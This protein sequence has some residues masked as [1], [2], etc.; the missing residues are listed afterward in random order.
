MLTIFALPLPFKD[1]D[2]FIQRNAIGSW[3]RL[4]PQPEILLLGDDDGVAE[5]AEEHGLRHIP[6]VAKNE[7]NRYSCDSIFELGQEHASNDL[8]MY[9]DADII[10][11]GESMH[12]IRM[13]ADEYEKFLVVGYRKGV[14]FSRDIDF[15]LTWEHRLHQ[16]VTHAG[17]DFRPK[18]RG[19]TGGGA[20]SDYFVFPRGL[21]KDMP[22]FTVGKGHWDGW[23]MWYAKQQGATL[24]DASEVIYA[25]HQNHPWRKW[26]TGPAMPA[27]YKLTN[28]NA[29]TLWTKDADIVLTDAWLDKRRP[30]LSIV[31]RCYKRP[32]MLAKNR[33]SAGAQIEGDFEQ[34]FIVDD[35]GKGLHWANR[36][37]HVNRARAMG[38]YVLILDD[39]DMFVDR[40]AIRYLK[41]ITEKHD[42]DV[43]I[44]KMDQILRNLPDMEWGK[45]IVRAHIGSC[46][47]VVKRKLWYD[48]IYVFGDP[49]GGLDDW[50]AGDCWF[51]D[52]LMKTGCSVYWFDKVLT[53]TQRVSK[54]NPE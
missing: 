9:I 17:K 18:Q 51:I 29:D 12:A 22:P 46:C 54:G 2:A 49:P 23:K 33:V 42:P 24:I 40:N 19:G 43:I 20:G 45:K 21:I 36:T 5:Y 6:G 30:F 41:A 32:K 10:L 11:T 35:I 3:M 13:V 38:E 31:T 25:V 7:L 47:F 26:N 14:Q 50:V 16:S 4:R 53:R 34:V 37:L 44:F 15:D 39:D 52:C 48:N 27:N 8:M 28:G 1:K